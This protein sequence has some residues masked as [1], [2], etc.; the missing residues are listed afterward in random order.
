MQPIPIPREV[1]EKAEA[2]GWR[3]LVIGPPDGATEEQVHSVEA[4]VGMTMFPDKQ[5][6]PELNVLVEMTEQDV[7]DLI[8]GGR[9]FWLTFEGHIVPFSLEIFDPEEVMTPADDQSEN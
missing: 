5:V 8:K 6:R 3:H 7:E 2:M 1:V 9:R 4:I